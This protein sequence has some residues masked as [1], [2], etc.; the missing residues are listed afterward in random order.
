M[1]KG[2]KWPSKKQGG[3]ANDP[4]LSQEQGH[5]E[6][7]TDLPFGVSG[8]AASE[9]VFIQASPNTEES[10]SEVSV[11]STPGLDDDHVSSRDSAIEYAVTSTNVSNAGNDKEKLQDDNNEGGVNFTEDPSAS[12]SRFSTSNV[13]SSSRR[14]P[15]EHPT[16]S[17]NKPG[18][19][20]RG[21]N[22]F[23]TPTNDT[24]E[25]IGIV[26][27]DFMKHIDHSLVVVQ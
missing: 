2:R 26:G 14:S 10:K 12:P 6:T 23:S 11:H 27:L 8:Q 20:I 3:K 24:D 5:E 18:G 13:H 1:V 25:G 16:S 19:I 9:M 17:S 21:K 15:R 22:K 4:K 7:S